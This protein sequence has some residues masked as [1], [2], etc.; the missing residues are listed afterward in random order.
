MDKAL[1]YIIQNKGLLKEARTFFL[2]NTKQF[3]T[4]DLLAKDYF[5]R[6][7]QILSAIN[8]IK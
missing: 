4:Y 5:D 6:N 3:P 1:T 8:N 7:P 2:E